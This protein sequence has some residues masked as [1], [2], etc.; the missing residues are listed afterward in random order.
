MEM[1]SRAS[2][3]FFITVYELE[4]LLK[5]A[6]DFFSSFFPC[7]LKLKCIH[8]TSRTHVKHPYMHRFTCDCCSMFI[9]SNTNGT[10]ASF[11]DNVFNDLHTQLIFHDHEKSVE[12]TICNDECDISCHSCFGPQ[13]MFADALA[14]PS[15][16]TAARHAVCTKRH[17]CSFVFGARRHVFWN[18]AFVVSMRSKWKNKLFI[19]AA[20]SEPL[21]V[22]VVV[23]AT[24]I[25]DKKKR[26]ISNRSTEMI[27]DQFLMIYFIF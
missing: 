13:C 11:T 16:A 15:A 4:W 20:M 14:V 12:K 9:V 5:I 22:R 2:W 17:E 26:N 24:A 10:V 7:E 6:R 18:R 21:G 1:E 25:N 8:F 19:W 3:S 23:W 27:T